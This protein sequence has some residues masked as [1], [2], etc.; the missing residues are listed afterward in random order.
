[1]TSLGDQVLASL[2]RVAKD[3][4]KAATRQAT[5]TVRKATGTR[6]PA[7]DDR[8]APKLSTTYPG[9]YRGTPHITYAPHTGKT[10]DPGEV[11]K[12][13]VPEAKNH[14]QGA[15][16]S[17]LL[18][19]RDGDWLLGLPVSTETEHEDGRWVS[20]GT[21]AWDTRRRKSAAR[22]DRVV[23]IHPD[24]VRGRAEKLDKARFDA[25]AAG[26]RRAR[27]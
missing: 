3:V 8:H 26:V 22:V 23:R 1:M 16:Q 17:V 7:S 2:N 11:V 19:G 25:V 21:G 20:I 6:R 10:P 9:D 13:W 12:A 5:G 27:S 24:D 18:V 14:R 4:L 15:D